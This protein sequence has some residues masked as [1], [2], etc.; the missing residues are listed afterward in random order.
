MAY[1]KFISFLSRWN[2]TVRDWYSGCLSFRHFRPIAWKQERYWIWGRYC[3]VA[4]LAFSSLFLWMVSV[5]FRSHNL[6]FQLL[7]ARWLFFCSGWKITKNMDVQLLREE[8]I[9]S[10]EKAFRSILGQVDDVLAE[11]E[12]RLTQ[13]EFGLTFEWRYYI[14][15]SLHRRSL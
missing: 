5:S 4:R 8:E 9:F 2:L 1:S 12:A 6:A 15:L 14:W 7:F 10:S 13:N 11:L 3:F